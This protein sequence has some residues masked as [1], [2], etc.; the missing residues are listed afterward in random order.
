MATLDISATLATV[1]ARSTRHGIHAVT[2]THEACDAETFWAQPDAEDLVLDAAGLAT[3]EY[4]LDGVTLAVD[5]SGTVTEE[6]KV[7]RVTADEG[8][9]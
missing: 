1:S 2:L 9:E 4:R 5:G 7:R 3:G 6:V 8:D